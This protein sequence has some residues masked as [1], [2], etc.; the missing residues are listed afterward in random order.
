MRKLSH[1]LAKSLV[2][3]PVSKPVY[4]LVPGE[5]LASEGRSFTIDQTVLCS[6]CVPFLA[7]VSRES[8]APM[9]LGPSPGSRYSCQ[10]RR[11]V[12]LSAR[13]ALCFTGIAWG[14]TVRRALP[15]RLHPAPRE[16]VW[17]CPP[18]VLFCAPMCTLSLF[19]LHLV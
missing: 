8:A 4:S 3:E 12:C 15:C 19:L 2:F 17:T 9:V 6:L 14:P 7:L 18:P 16:R 13:P 11:C 1:L 10:H 5:A